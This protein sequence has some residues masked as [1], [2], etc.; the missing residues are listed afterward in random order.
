MEF[1]DDEK[2][3]VWFDKVL[4]REIFLRTEISKNLKKDWSFDRLP[5]LEKAVLVYA[6][7]ELIFGQKKDYRKMIIDQA[8]NFSKAY[9]EEGKYRYINKNLDLSLKKVTKN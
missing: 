7:H 1:F 2:K 9:L 4:Q 3:T 8:I 6:T 5:P